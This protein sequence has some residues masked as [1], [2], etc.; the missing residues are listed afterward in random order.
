MA[1]ALGSLRLTTGPQ[2]TA[3]EVEHGCRALAAVAALV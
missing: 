1:E 2:T 3:A